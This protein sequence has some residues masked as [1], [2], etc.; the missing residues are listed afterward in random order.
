MGSRCEPRGLVDNGIELAFGVFVGHDFKIN[1]LDLASL[2][3]RA[4]CLEA[5]LAD[6]LGCC[7]C[8]LEEF[9]RIEFALV[10]REVAADR[11]G[12]GEAE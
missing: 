1:R 2:A 4:E 5:R 12:H 8:I 6:F 10:A 9:A 7:G 3:R 11:A